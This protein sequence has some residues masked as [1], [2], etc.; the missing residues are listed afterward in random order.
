MDG[1]ETFRLL[2][3][4]CR[5][6]IVALLGQRPHTVAELI[7][8]LGR[9]QSNVSHHLKA[10]REAGLVRSRYVG[11]FVLY[12][13]KDPMLVQLVTLGGHVAARVDER[14][15]CVECAQEDQV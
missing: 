2:S 1:A 5:L 12:E 9:E 11:K 7:V 13:L 6:R 4:D 15:E 10:L 3:D 8:A 14:C